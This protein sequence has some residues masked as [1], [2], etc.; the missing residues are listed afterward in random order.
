MLVEIPGHHFEALVIVQ[1]NNWGIL[2]RGGVTGSLSS[3][4]SAVQEDHF[5]NARNYL[6]VQKFRNVLC[7]IDNR[8]TVLVEIS[9]LMWMQ[10]TDDSFPLLDWFFF[11]ESH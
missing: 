11:I 4:I 6:C 1:V 10:F 9:F 7:F 8:T 3:N 2:V 5:G